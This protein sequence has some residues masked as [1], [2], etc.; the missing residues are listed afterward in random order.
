MVLDTD[1]YDLSDC[2]S[3]GEDGD[4]WE[5]DFGLDY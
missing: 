1:F 3:G 4:C 2:S 5:E